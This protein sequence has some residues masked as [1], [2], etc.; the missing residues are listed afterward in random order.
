[1]ALAISLLGRDAKRYPPIA[2]VLMFMDQKS[3]RFPLLQKLAD[4]Q[5]TSSMPSF[6][7]LPLG[8][9]LRL[10]QGNEATDKRDKV[11]ALLGLSSDN[12]ISPQL[13]PDYTKSWSTLFQQVIKHILGSSPLV[14]TDDTEQAIIF[15]SGSVLGTISFGWHDHLIVQSPT[16]GGLYDNKYHWK[17]SWTLTHHGGSIRDGDILVFF[18]NARGPSVIRPCGDHFDIVM[19]SLPLPPV[20]TVVLNSPRPGW[21]E[22]NLA[23]ADFAQ[24]ARK[25]SRKFHLIW[26][27]TDSGDSVYHETL[28]DQCQA[29]ASESVERRFATARVLDDLFDVHNLRTLLV[30]RTPTND[31]KGMEKHLILLDHTLVH[32]REYVRMKHCFTTLQ[33]CIWAL[34]TP[35]GT[36]YLLDYWRYAGPISLDLYE[37]LNLAKDNAEKEMNLSNNYHRFCWTV[38][39]RQHE[40]YSLIFPSYSPAIVLEGHSFTIEPHN[41]RYLTRLVV[42][43]QSSTI[44]PSEAAITRLYDSLYFDTQWDA[45][46]ML[47]AEH[48][49]TSFLE[50]YLADLALERYFHDYNTDFLSY[51]FLEIAYSSIATWEFLEYLLVDIKDTEDQVDLFY[52]VL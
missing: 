18:Q 37:I 42:A 41:S 50:P 40:L 35:I 21:R 2:S 43:S 34:N 48:G 22:F 7:I 16:F 31:C 15:E 12:D 10:F 32:W 30:N 11:Y 23:W 3:A 47:L 26:D 6:N 5:P 28:L 4:M 24:G 14:E 44:E 13:R 25:S 33:W 1:M 52:G 29:P 19:I 9:L 39:H 36:N 46:M 38:E 51:I 20:V 17:A 8:E 49:P 45:V 27:W